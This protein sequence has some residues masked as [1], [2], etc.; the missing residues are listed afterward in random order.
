MDAPPIR[1]LAFNRMTLWHANHHQHTP[2]TCKYLSLCKDMYCMR[3]RQTYGLVW[4]GMSFSSHW[5]L[6][7]TG[8]LKGTG[9]RYSLLEHIITPCS[10]IT[11]QSSS[12]HSIRK[13]L[14]CTV[15]TD[16]NF[17]TIGYLLLLYVC[18]QV[19]RYGYTFL[20]CLYVCLSAI[21]R[22]NGTIL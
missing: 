6:F 7:S 17:A 19:Y 22:R 15:V 1:L 20:T 3:W 4:K 14:F 2:L 18:V 21:K 10:L 16:S 12:K 8:E 13:V 11:Q 5:P 9:E